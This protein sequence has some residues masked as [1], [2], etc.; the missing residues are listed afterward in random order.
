MRIAMTGSSG[1]IGSALMARFEQD[2]HAVTRVVRGAGVRDPRHRT[3]VWDPAAGT[4]DRAGLEAHDAVV[5]LAGEDI[6]A[7]RWTQARKQVIR[8]S[9]IR[10]TLLLCET[11][12][13]LAHKPRVLITASGVGYYG[14]HE[15]DD[16]VDETSARGTGFLADLVRDWE[17]ATAP[18]K[19]AGIRVVHTRFGIVLSP[20]GGALA[21][22]LPVFRMGLGGKVGS[23]RQ[24]MS[25]IALDDVPSVMLH[26][27]EHDSLS[28]PVNVVS[29]HAV[30]NAEFTRILGQVLGRPA[31]L[32]LPGFAARLLFG[33]MA[34]ALL[35][36]GARVI[37]KRLED[38]G[39]RFAYPR[40][41]QALSHLLNPPTG[42][43]AS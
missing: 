41:D 13:G 26:L 1:L 12:A 28:G 11:L 37:P 29:P 2:G 35:L 27:I 33:E 7:G 24:A 31:I 15:P 5:H 6:A 40:L 30:T 16:R 34:D 42:H 38:T 18:A 32:P 17:Q 4:I 36:G 39:Y 14:H 20:R 21:K 43:R 8:E 10:G 23:G 19:A 22:M 3:V 25:W 9:R